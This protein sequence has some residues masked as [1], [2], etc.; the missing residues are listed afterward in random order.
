MTCPLL[1]VRMKVSTWSTSCYKGQSTLWGPALKNWHR[2]NTVCIGFKK[3]VLKSRVFKTCLVPSCASTAR[4][5]IG[6]LIGWLW[7]TNQGAISSTIEPKRSSVF[8]CYGHAW[9]KGQ[10]WKNI[11]LPLWGRSLRQGMLN[12]PPHPLVNNS[13]GI[14]QSLEF[15]TCVN[16]AKYK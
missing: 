5:I 6:W 9:K 8:W 4:D 16:Q 2:S 14:F 7:A 15:I 12:Q 10:T 13:A 1:S 11:W 3:E